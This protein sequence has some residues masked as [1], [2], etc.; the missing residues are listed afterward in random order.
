MERLSGAIADGQIILKSYEIERNSALLTLKIK[1]DSFLCVII[2][3]QASADTHVT[4]QLS[5]GEV[6][7][8]KTGVSL[9]CF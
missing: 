3:N 4:G 1:P 2:A 7:F 8:Y 6:P 5:E 9:P